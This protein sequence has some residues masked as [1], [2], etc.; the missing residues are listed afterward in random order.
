MDS[1]MKKDKQNIVMNNQPEAYKLNQEEKQLL[2]EA[3]FGEVRYGGW[4]LTYDE[5]GKNPKLYYSPHMCKIMGV[6]GAE[7]ENPTLETWIAH[8]HPQ[9]RARVVDKFNATFSNGN[10]ATYDDIYRSRLS[11]G[12]Y[13]WFKDKGI[14]FY[15]ED[16]T[17]EKVLG[18]V[19]DV[20]DTVLEQKR[21]HELEAVRDMTKA[22]RWT[23]TYDEATNDESITMSDE[24]R[25]ILGFANEEELPNTIDA[26][27]ARIHPEDRDEAKAATRAAF[28]D[29]TEKSVFTKNIRMRC[30]NEEYKW[31]HIATKAV[32][33]S[34]SQTTSAVGV[35]V[36]VNDTVLR[37]QAEEKLKL[38]YATQEQQLTRISLLNNRLEETIKAAEAANIAKSNFLF[39]MSHDIRTPMNAIIG[40]NKL[41]KRDA[42]DVEKV[43]RYQRQIDAASNFLLTIINNVLDMARIESGKMEIEN[44]P[45]NAGTLLPGLIDIFSIEANS[46]DIAI[47]YS[48]NIVHRHILFDKAKVEE[49][50]ANIISNAIKY[51]QSGGTI[52]I[53]TDELPADDKGRVVLKTVVEDNGYGMS[54]D[55][56][57]DIF[58]P[59]EREHNT[60][61]S[62]VPGTGLGMAIVK[63]LVE[64]L[65]G[66]VEIE[67]ELGKGTKV[68]VYLPHE[69]ASQT[70]AETLEEQCSTQEYRLEFLKGKHVL[71]VEDNELNAE[72]ATE[73]IEGFG[74]KVTYAENG[75]ICLEK[76][77]LAE[78]GTYDFVLMDIQMPVMNGLVATKAIRN[79]SDP[80]KANIP[81][82]AMTANAFSE[83]KKKALEVG[84]NGF[85]SKP[86]D[87]GAMLM[88]ISRLVK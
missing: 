57:K 37:E 44:N 81:I 38:S 47:T 30:K 63:K 50:F 58:T 17:L 73:I 26:L 80:R 3:M 4:K 76:L 70:E 31:I 79:L 15:R 42:G 66:S 64:Y 49:I 34:F 88:E 69:L 41:M 86:I 19:R 51:T 6:T 8:L 40:Y 62:S 14:I 36:D 65:D 16:G 46:K 75:V 22:A 52:K 18:F 48:N 13:R 33:D 25:R 56:L 78:A 87:V 27:A 23:H 71:L 53:S 68:A 28:L 59:F 54:Q 55:F 84:M 20:T 5:Q 35:F 85:T 12:K 32:Y 74:M 43:L 45:H 60:T 10:S 29:K 83:D 82:I 39:N 7:A 77:K 1:I 21:R 2:Y 72:I 24:L 9:D 67:S 11:N 61:I